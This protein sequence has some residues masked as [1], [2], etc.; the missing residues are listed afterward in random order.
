MGQA[1]VGQPLAGPEVQAGEHGVSLQALQA[2]F[3]QPGATAEAEAR[4]RA[5][6]PE[7]LQGGVREAAAVGEVQKP[8]AQTLQG[9]GGEG[10]SGCAFCK[11]YG[12][13]GRYKGESV[14]RSGCV[15]W[16]SG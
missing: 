12:S 9:I 7:D 6:P 15:F 10:V 3:C 2:G 4:Q 5:I 14:S 8:Q 13:F 16:G 11:A 1:V